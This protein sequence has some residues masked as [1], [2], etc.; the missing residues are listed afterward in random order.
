MLLHCIKPCYDLHF[1]EII[2]KK[3]T[4]PKVTNLMLNLLTFIHSGHQSSDSSP[5]FQF[6]DPDIQVSYNKTIYAWHF[7]HF[8]INNVWFQ[9]AE[10]SLQTL[11]LP[12]SDPMTP[13]RV[14]LEATFKE[15]FFPMMPH[16]MYCLPLWPGITLVLLTKVLLDFI[17]NPI[18]FNVKSFF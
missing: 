15:G 2:F 16:S 12:V 6:M 18:L 1:L 4:V 10:D 5:I 3:I 7:Y 14:F 9:I 17:F 13:T 8:C 11:Q